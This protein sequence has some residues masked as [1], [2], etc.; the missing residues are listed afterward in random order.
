MPG[1]TGNVNTENW[2]LELEGLVVY[3]RKNNCFK[4]FPPK[5]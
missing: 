2:H 5:A 3:K 1:L 4:F